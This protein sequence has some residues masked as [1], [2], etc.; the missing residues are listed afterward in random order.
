MTT[1]IIDEKSPAGR[2]VMNYIRSLKDIPADDIKILD[3]DRPLCYSTKELI[4]S[5]DEVEALYLAQESISHEEILKRF[6]Q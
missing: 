6:A 3:E 4:D 1:I 2:R 5:L